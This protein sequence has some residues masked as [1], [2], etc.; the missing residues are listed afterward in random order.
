[1]GNNYR[2]LDVTLTCKRCGK[3]FHPWHTARNPMFCS[4]KCYRWTY[5]EIE[6]LKALWGRIPAKKIAERLG[7]SVDAVCHKARRMNLGHGYVWNKGLNKKIDERVRRTA[8]KVAKTIKEKWINDMDYREK[9]LKAIKENRQHAKPWLGKSLPQ[10]VKEKISEIKKEQWKNLPEHKKEML[11]IKRRLQWLDPSY[12]RKVRDGLRRRPTNFE[13]SFA[14]CFPYLTYVG[15]LRFFVG[16][17]NPDFI[18]KG[19]NKCIDLFGDYWHIGEN[20]QERIEYFRKR[21]YE[22]L[23]IWESEWKNNRKKVIEKIQHFLEAN[24]NA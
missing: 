19:T 14:E 22:L 6:M 17:R 3:P 15:D 9:T 1:M 8:S 10:E 13:K 21:G 5:E 18:L 2:L 20:P 24:K 11:R 7:R 4:R 12:Q 23:I 16:S